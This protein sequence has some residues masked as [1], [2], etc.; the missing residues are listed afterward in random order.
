MAVHMAGYVRVYSSLVIKDEAKAK[1]F[2]PRSRPKTRIFFK[3][4]AKTFF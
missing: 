3:A 4:K 1:T 2:W